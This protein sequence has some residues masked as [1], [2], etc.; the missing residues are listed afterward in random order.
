MPIIRSDR[1]ARKRPRSVRS[2]NRLEANSAVNRWAVEIGRPASRAMSDSECSL[3]SVNVS[4]IEV[5]L[6]VTDRPGSVELP[7]TIRP[8]PHCPVR[9]DALHA[10]SSRLV[11]GRAINFF[12]VRTSVGRHKPI[13]RLGGEKVSRRHDR[14]ARALTPAIR[15]QQAGPPGGDEVP[16]PAA[17][18]SRFETTTAPQ[19]CQDDRG[20]DG[21]VRTWT[22][23]GRG[24]EHRPLRAMS[25]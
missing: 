24:H 10:R 13:H 7:A 6:L 9:G 25:E 14:Q 3:P 19:C 23:L 21:V 18:S 1:P 15:R 22:Q 4:R 2:N 5:I 16:R 8:R 20:Q 12:H 17:F 11:P